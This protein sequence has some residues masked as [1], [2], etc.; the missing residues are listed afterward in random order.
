M[1]LGRGTLR[2]AL[3]QV[4]TIVY[5]V[6]ALHLYLMRALH[7]LP[8]FFVGA[9]AGWLPQGLLNAGED[10]GRQRWMVPNRLGDMA[11]GSEAA[12]RVPAEPASDGSPADTKQLRTILTR[13]RGRTREQVEHLEAGFFAT[14]VFA[15]QA[16][17]EVRNTFS[18]R[19]NGFAQRWYLSKWAH[20]CSYEHSRSMHTSQSEFI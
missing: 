20:D 18:N 19:W 10:V 11:Q 14:I 1:W 16:L 3:K 6:L 8:Q 4:R 13:V 17:L 7:P 2:V 5:S 12:G 9:K 15:L